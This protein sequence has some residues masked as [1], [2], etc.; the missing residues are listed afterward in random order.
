MARRMEADIQLRVYE[1]SDYEMVAAW[2]RGHKRH[3]NSPADSVFVPPHL[4]P[5]I[6][7]IAFRE[8]EDLAALWL[9]LAQASPVCFAEHALTKPGLDAR[10]ASLALLSITCALEEVA[11][12]FGYQLMVVH[13][14]PAM[15][16]Y[17]QRVRWIQGETG[18]TTLFRALEAQHANL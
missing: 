13:T 1:P 14:R 5:P 6:G 18:M 10:T 2:N 15:A 12:G 3:P 9:Y 7:Q 8:D 4:L 17:M 11:T 16:R